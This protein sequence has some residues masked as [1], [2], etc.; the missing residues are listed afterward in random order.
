MVE[1]YLRNSEA[2]GHAKNSKSNKMF[3]FYVKFICSQITPSQA[4]MLP[5]KYYQ[6]NS[7]NEFTYV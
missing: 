4:V 2:Y 1:I 7:S 5:R 6:P 3:R